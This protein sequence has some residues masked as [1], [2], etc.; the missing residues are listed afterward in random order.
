MGALQTLSNLALAVRLP[1]LVASIIPTLVATALAVYD[2]YFS[3]YVFAAI[4]AA[5]L[6]SHAGTNLANDY[7]DYKEGNY[8]PKKTGPTGGSFAIQNKLFSPTRILLLALI[9]FITSLLI[10]YIT[11]IYTTSL[12]FVLG[13]IGNFIGLAYSAPPFKLGYRQL[14]EAATFFGMG[15]L[16]MGT[17]YLSQTGTITAGLLALSF[18]F[19]FLI[20]NILL[21]AQLPDI[22]IDKKSNKKTIASVWGKQILQQSYSFCTILAIASLVFGVLFLGLPLVLLIGVIGTNFSVVAIKNMQ[23]DDYNEALKQTIFALQVAGILIIAGIMVEVL[24]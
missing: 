3:P 21:V 18:F 2:G 9:C 5:I 6:L 12:V 14:G 1:F 20:C 16:L 17:V 7:F 11:S 10:F 15:P 4:A 19:G 23:R 24:I 22:E 13:F 8:P